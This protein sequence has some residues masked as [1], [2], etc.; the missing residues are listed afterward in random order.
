MASVIS[1]DVTEGI[2][3]AASTTEHET[4]GE[5][6]TSKESDGEKQLSHKEAMAIWKEGLAEMIE[7]RIQK[8]D[9][10]ENSLPGKLDLR[11]IISDNLL[12]GG[13]GR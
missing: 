6:Q 11:V 2:S 3:T 13:I 5:A 10:W 9:W 8:R 1:T 12:G 4:D 7:V